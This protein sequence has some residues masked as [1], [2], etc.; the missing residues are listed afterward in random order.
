MRAN[1]LLMSVLRRNGGENWLKISGNQIFLCGG[2]F[3]VVNGFAPANLGW[4]GGEG[5][6]GDGESSP[7][8]YG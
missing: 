4:F 3:C 6:Y 8:Q 2:D 5:G 1:P 7:S